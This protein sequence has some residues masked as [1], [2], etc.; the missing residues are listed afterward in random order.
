MYEILKAFICFI[1]PLILFQ[2]IRFLIKFR[3]RNSQKINGELFITE[4]LEDCC[5][6]C[7]AR[8]CCDIHP[9]HIKSSKEIREDLETVEEKLPDEYEMKKA[10]EKSETT[11]LS[12]EAERK[13]IIDLIGNKQ[14][15]SLLYLCNRSSLPKQRV[16]EIVLQETNFRLEGEYLIDI[17]ASAME[18]TWEISSD[19]EKK[20][21]EEKIAEGICPE[22]NNPID[23]SSEYCKS[24]GYKIY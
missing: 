7:F 16:I 6:S 22:C 10:L 2:Q 19:Q 18:G 3:K 13:K 8:S 5:C 20:G 24:C 15:V 23:P 21:R 11:Y 9:R 14:K 1:L 4:E 17:S 12:E